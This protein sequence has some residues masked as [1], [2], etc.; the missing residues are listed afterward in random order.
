MIQYLAHGGHGAGMG[1]PALPVA[2]VFSALL[3]AGTALH[4]RARAPRP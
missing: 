3:V 2:V 1:L 4:R